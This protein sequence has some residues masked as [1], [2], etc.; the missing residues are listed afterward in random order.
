LISDVCISGLM[1]SVEKGSG[2]GG[3]QV[4]PRRAQERGG[5]GSG[6][7]RGEVEILGVDEMCV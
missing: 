1:N 5:D 6:D 3:V 7:G 4:E 2:D